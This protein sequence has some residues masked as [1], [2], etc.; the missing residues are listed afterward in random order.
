[1]GF[2][3]T[4]D[5]NVNMWQVW[6]AAEICC[7]SGMLTRILRFGGYETASVDI[8]MW[9]SQVPPPPPTAN[10]PLDLL[11]PSGFALLS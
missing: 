1:M 9:T 11:Q 10:N 3:V 5:M 6:D 8:Q 7:G 2:G 4:W